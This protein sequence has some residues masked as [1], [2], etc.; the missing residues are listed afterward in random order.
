MILQ[1][2]SHNNE[3]G[4]SPPSL[5]WSC[6]FDAAQD[7]AVFLGFKCTYPKFFISK[8]DGGVIGEGLHPSVLIL[9]WQHSTPWK[10][11]NDWTNIQAKLSSLF[12]K[13]CCQMSGHSQRKLTTL[14]LCGL[15]LSSR[16]KQ[17]SSF[18]S[19]VRLLPLPDTRLFKNSQW[20][21]RKNILQSRIYIL[22]FMQ[23]LLHWSLNLV[24][25]AVFP[26]IFDWNKNWGFQWTLNGTRMNSR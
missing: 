19:A 15:Y 18:S 9:G 13:C 12:L 22:V 4:Q 10:R 1:M 23:I 17:R 20:K 25:K 21:R 8:K 2:G 6:L 24:N 3:G 7:N 26:W 16:Y 11:T 14:L 5:C